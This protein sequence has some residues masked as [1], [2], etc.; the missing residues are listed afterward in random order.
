MLVAFD[1]W[2]IN[3]NTTTTATATTTT[4]PGLMVYCFYY[5]IFILLLLLLLLFLL[6]YRLHDLMSLKRTTSKQRHSFLIT[7]KPTRPV[8]LRAIQLVNSCGE[9]A[10]H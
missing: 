2:L 7:Q 6:V 8:M 5:F 9:I 10:F 3:E 4:S 1:N